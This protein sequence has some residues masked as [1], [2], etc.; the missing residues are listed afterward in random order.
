MLLCEVGVR[1]LVCTTRPKAIVELIVSI[2]PP[3]TVIFCGVLG[4]G[5]VSI[6]K[7][8]FQMPRLIYL[9]WDT[10]EEDIN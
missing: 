5:S 6:L 4:Q 1:I 10:A 2:S 3:D 9:V 8:C 7:D